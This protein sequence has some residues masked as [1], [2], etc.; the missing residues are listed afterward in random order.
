MHSTA[1]GSDIFMGFMKASEPGCENGCINDYWT[2]E[3]NTPELDAQQDIIFRSFSS[4]NGLLTME[5][6]RLLDTGDSSNDRVITPQVQQYVIYAVQKT[7]VPTSKTQFQMHTLP[8]QGAAL[9]TFGQ[10]STCPVEGAIELDITL[11]VHPDN[12]EEVSNFHHLLT[13]FPAS[14][15]C[16]SCCRTSSRSE[17]LGRA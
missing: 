17:S 10:P 2:V 6:S 3:R 11:D 12:Y 4:A 1:E 5:F 13:S 9:V 14:I 8:Y 15:S 7:A 16:S